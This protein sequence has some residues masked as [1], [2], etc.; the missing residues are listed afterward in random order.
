MASLPHPIHRVPPEVLSEILIQGT[1][2][3]YTSI[4]ERSSIISPSHVCRDWR[5]VALSTPS[6]WTFIL[7][8]CPRDEFLPREL[9]CIHAWLSR[10]GRCAL[11]ITTHSYRS[12]HSKAPIE[13]FIPHCMR[14]REID[15]RIFSAVN[16]HVTSQIKGNMPLLES[17][18]LGFVESHTLIDL[19]AVAPRLRR[20][21]L[22]NCSPF[23]LDLVT[24]PWAQLV[25]LDI[26][27]D[28]EPSF[29]RLL[30][31]AANVTFLNVTICHGFDT[32]IGITHPNILT[33]HAT[34][35]SSTLT[36]D[37]LDRLALPALRDLRLVDPGWRTASFISRSACTLSSLQIGMFETSKFVELMELLPALQELSVTFRWAY[38]WEAM[39][40]CLA[41]QHN[42]RLAPDLRSLTMRWPCWPPAKYV[43][44]ISLHSFA[45]MLASRWTP[46]G[47]VPDATSIRSPLNH[48]RVDR[49]VSTKIVES[50][51]ALVCLQRLL[52][53]GLD[54]T[55]LTDDN[56]PRDLLA[57][58]TIYELD[59]GHIMPFLRL[60]DTS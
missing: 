4:S 42:L 11:T 13:P 10:S 44:D 39:A 50:T 28:T 31:L 26:E 3:R 21:K 43:E 23:E 48:V 2:L 53:E 51:S 40:E 47:A 52:K 29:L 38:E 60:A 12:R 16:P 32:N 17:A 9:D 15:T 25:H 34:T 1:P 49:C 56:P 5:S 22:E 27:T 33:M 6:L 59:A 36:D 20:L 30:V 45:I 58:R 24:L 19:F 14:W 7:F 55:L 18:D 37:L 57:A 35:S 54:V 41:F 46:L 8:R